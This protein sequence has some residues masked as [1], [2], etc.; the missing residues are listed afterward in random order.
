MAKVTVYTKAWC[1][2]C[3]RAKYVLTQKGVEFDEIDIGAN[4][5]LREQMIELSGRQ[6]VPQIFINEH[7]VGG[8]DDLLEAD[9]DGELDRLL[10]T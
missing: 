1:P 7:H 10:N 5:E 3:T 9:L 2:F 4:P 8:C 6:T